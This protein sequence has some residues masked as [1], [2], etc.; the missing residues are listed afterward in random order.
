MVYNL[1]FT[2]STANQT[3]ALGGNCITI[4]ITSFTVF[5]GLGRLGQLFH[6]QQLGGVLHV[7]EDLLLL[8]PRLL[9]WLL[10]LLLLQLGLFLELF[11]GRWL[12]FGLRECR[13]LFLECARWLW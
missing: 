11:G 4:T 3:S 12:D 7:N 6:L 5:L 9:L 2:N 10:L 13:P 1:N 8:L